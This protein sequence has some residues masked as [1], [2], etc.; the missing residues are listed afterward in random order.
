MPL[1]SQ[2]PE[3]ERQLGPFATQAKNWVG[4]RTSSYA[5]RA[6]LSAPLVRRAL[7]RFAARTK[8]CPSTRA[9]L[10]PLRSETSRH[11]P[12]R[13]TA[14]RRRH[15]LRAPT[16]RRACRLQEFDRD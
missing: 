4:R 11:E 12:L 1:K 3:R 13:H 9:V 14:D 2:A 10:K 6:A 8:G 16:I 5:P 7:A 15:A